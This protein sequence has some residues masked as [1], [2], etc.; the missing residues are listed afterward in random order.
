MRKFIVTVMA[1][2]LSCSGA[3]AFWADATDSL[4]EIGVGYRQ[5]RLEWKL[6]RSD[7]CSYSGESEDI[8]LFTTPVQSK[9]KWH[10][11]RI[12]QIE[13]AGKYVTCDNLYLRATGD[14]GW[15]TSGKNRD[16]DNGYSDN[17]SYGDSWSSNSRSH[18]KGHVYDADI[19]VGYQF[20]WCDD[21]F[22][23]YPL[24][25]YAW[26]GQHF[27][28]NCLDESSGCGDYSYGYDYSSYG[29][30]N[31][32]YHARWNG[33][34][35]G[36]DFDYRFGCGCDMDWQLFGT[37]EFHWTEYHA[38]ANWRYNPQ[39]CNGFK[40][41]ADCGYG[42]VFDI[43]VRWDF[44]ECWTLA[45][46]GEFRWYWADRGHDSAKIASCSECGGNI[47]CYLKL[48]LRDLRWDSAAVSVDLGM[49]F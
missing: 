16:R 21:A 35:V 1:S 9:V 43:G 22:A 28:D 40:H 20:K 39:L 26:N 12:W 2:L 27:H 23:I 44:C 7:C 41:H 36:F 45:V 6:G 30:N 47:D 17:N 42:N 10:D 32:S 34:F 38:S 19:A 8:N 5:D 3:F 29:G 48:P 25:G 18:V 24:V 14:Y 13:A 11:L 15:I 33:P 4:L 31:S 37:Y 46:K 49:V